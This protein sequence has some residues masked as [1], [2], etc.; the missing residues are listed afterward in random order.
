MKENLLIDKSIAFA[1]R[2]IK[3]HQ[4]LIKTKKET[5]IS[6]QI[7]R[8]GTSIG[9]NINEAN[10]GQSKADFVCYCIHMDIC[11]NRNVE[12]DYFRGE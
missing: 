5:I 7:V 1:S 12:N 3:L 8:S 2:I 10:Y 11:Y 9:A 6:K 4:Y